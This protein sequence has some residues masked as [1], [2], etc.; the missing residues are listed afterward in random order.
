MSFSEGLTAGSN[1]I[2]SI[3]AARQTARDNARANL[4][5][6]ALVKQYGAVAGDPENW[7][8]VAAA[9]TEAAKAPYAGP[10]AAAGVANTQAQT[11]QTQATTAGLTG[12]Q[13]RMAQYRATQMLGDYVDPKTGSVDPQAFDKV[14]GD[15]SM[16]GIDPQ[17]LGPLKQMVT[18]P[19]GAAHLSTISQALIGPAKVAGAST[20]IQN[21]DGAYAVAREDQYGRMTTQPL[22][23][24]AAPVVAQ[25]TQQRV[26]QGN[27]RLQQGQ[28]R[29][30]IA[31][32]NANTGAYRAD[33]TS[34]NSTFGASGAVAA[35]QTGAVPS[36][37]GLDA[38]IAKHG[39]IDAALAATGSNSALTN[40][41]ADRY[42][43][44]NKL[45]KYADGAVTPASPLDHLPPKG[46]QMVIGQAQ[47]LANQRT[48]LNNTNA[49]LDQVTQQITPYTAGGGSLLNA[50]PG[51]VQ[52]NLK[53]NLETLSA[54]GLTSWIQSLKNAQGQTGIGRVL[55]SEANAA[56]K[57]YGNMEQDQS[58]KQLLYHSQLFRKAVNDLNDHAHQAFKA[59]WKVDPETIV[60]T[61]S[62]ASSYNSA[63][64]A[65]LSKYGL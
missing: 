1:F 59:Q 33:V 28:E 60:G 22:P 40:A 7:L 52:K 23:T 6:D 58:A 9:Q 43:Q 10:E 3:T 34:N 31:Q 61:E 18:A 64:K 32:Q 30:G 44:V 25:A 38:F 46:R 8:K 12:D 47:Q 36:A 45:G 56:M 4:A 63:Q 14:I 49:I 50:I 55:Q 37:S 57:L 16:L 26:A 5:R 19:G 21:P 17:H 13:Q 27:V 65:A 41:V 48:N 2:D 11:A 15:G 35:P 53:A 39:N 24:G 20:V 54:Q 62:K 51:T 29:V 42:E